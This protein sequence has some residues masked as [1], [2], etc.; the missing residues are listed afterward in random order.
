MGAPTSEQ[1]RGQAEQ[2]QVRERQV[3]GFQR[4]RQREGQRQERQLQILAVRQTYQEW[5][6]PRHPKKGV[7]RALRA[8]VEGPLALGDVGVVVPKPQKICQ[9]LC[10]G[11][12]LL[13]RGSCTLK[14]LQIVAGGLVYLAMFRRPLLCA[15]NVVW[16]FTQRLKVVP[17]VVRLSVPPKVRLEL[18]RF[19]ASVP[20]AQMSFRALPWGQATCSDASSHGG[21]FCAS[22]GLTAYGMAAAKSP[23]RGDVLEPH[24]ACQVLSV[25]LFDGLGALRV[26]CDLVGL[27]MAGHVSVESDGAARRVVES[28]FAVT[29]FHDDAR[30]VDCELVF[31]WSCRFQKGRD[32]PAKGSQ[33]STAKRKAHSKTIAACCSWKSLGS[34]LCFASASHGH[35]STSLVKAWCL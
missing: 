19:L 29:I 28:F 31:Q 18:F 5:G 26:A 34:F 27:P 25:G 10:L 13:R 22:S 30:S 1:R 9:Y 21:G 32:P 24:D 17:P 23:G 33:A 4:E 12:E 11:M 15:L 35:R 6:V 20:L 8:E 3:Q 2:G 7:A 14:E 16:V